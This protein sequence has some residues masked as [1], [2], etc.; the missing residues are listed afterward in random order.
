MRKILLMMLIVLLVGC[1]SRVEPTKVKTVVE[2]PEQ[3][4]EIKEVEYVE[5]DQMKA[6]VL[7]TN[8]KTDVVDIALLHERLSVK[9]LD[10]VDLEVSID[11]QMDLIDEIIRDELY[12]W[13]EELVKLV[14]EENNIELNVDD[15]ET[16]VE[17]TSYN[18]AYQLMSVYEKIFLEKQQ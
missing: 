16:L 3:V 6:L 13:K 5:R 14:L 17:R 7:L 11:E 10:A 15:Y 9:L 1:R 4:E 2:E 8:K 12:D 18:D